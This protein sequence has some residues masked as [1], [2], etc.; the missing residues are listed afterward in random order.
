[1]DVSDNKYILSKVN[2]RIKEMNDLEKKIGINSPKKENT[3]LMNFTK[4]LN[5]DI[6]SERSM[7]NQIFSSNKKE[8][9]IDYSKNYTNNNTSEKEY[10]IVNHMKSGDSNTT[11]ISIGTNRYNRNIICGRHEEE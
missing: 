5:E 11:A 1:M 8:N 7:I 9:K 2:E 10:N 3:L 4:E 6:S